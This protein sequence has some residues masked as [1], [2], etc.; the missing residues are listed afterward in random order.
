MSRRT[1]SAGNLDL[2]ATMV[3]MILVVIGAAHGVQA[4]EPVSSRVSLPDG[5]LDQVFP[6]YVLS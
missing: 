1:S 3:A 4:G 5:L 2:L 6:A